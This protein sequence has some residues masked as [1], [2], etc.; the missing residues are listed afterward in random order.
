MRVSLMG[1]HC[2]HL[3]VAQ[4]F[5]ISC[6]FF[7][8]LMD[9]VLSTSGC[10][11]IL[12][13]FAVDW[14]FGQEYAALPLA[15]ASLIAWAYLGWFLLGFKSTGPFIIMIAH[16]KLSITYLLQWFSDGRKSHSLM[17]TPLTLQ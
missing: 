10:S 11:L 4:V 14:A 15:S 2:W 13:S 5:K 8:G 12:L 17:F 9:S 6:V 3:C 16:S 7:V 1:L